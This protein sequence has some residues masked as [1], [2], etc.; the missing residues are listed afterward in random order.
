M[1]VITQEEFDKKK[2]ELLSAHQAVPVLQQASPSGSVPGNSFPAA[3]TPAAGFSKPAN[4]FNRKD[5]KKNT[6]LIAG[7]AAGVLILII[8]L[9]S[10]IPV[11]Q[12]KI[13]GTWDG[14]WTYEGNSFEKIILFE[15]DSTFTSLTYKN[16][17]ASDLDMGT[18]EIRGKKVILHS[19]INNGVMTEYKYKRGKLFNNGH[20]LSK[21]S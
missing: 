5:N 12:S 9:A 3:A 21:I 14:S 6:I 4:K 13:V 20:G 7:I 19:S 2:A 18:Y 10:L 15:T 1:G 8:L 16:G 11:K 17:S